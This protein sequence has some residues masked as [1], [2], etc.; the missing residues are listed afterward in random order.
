MAVH[1][2]ERL[3]TLCTASAAAI[4]CPGCKA[5]SAIVTVKGCEIDVCRH[6]HGIWIDGDEILR[7]ESLFPKKSEILLA[8]RTGYQH[9]QTD[10]TPA[11]LV[12]ELLNIIL[13]FR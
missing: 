10:W 3:P 6:C 8:T 2:I 7:L 4:P 9:Q 1:G 12:W 11:A 5:E 13:A